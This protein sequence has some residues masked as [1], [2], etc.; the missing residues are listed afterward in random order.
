[1]Q[2]TCCP[3]TCRCASCG[4]CRA[5]C[6][7][8]CC[9]PWRGGGTP[10]QSWRVSRRAAG[11]SA[12][13]APGCL[14]ALP[15]ACRSGCSP[16][17]PPA[18]GPSKPLPSSPCL[19]A[20]WPT[21]R[22]WATCSSTSCCLSVPSDGWRPRC[23]C[24]RTAATCRCWCTA[25]TVGAAAAAAASAAPAIAA[26]GV[27]IA[28]STR[29]WH[30]QVLPV[31]LRVAAFNSLR[32]T[33]CPPPC[34]PTPPHPTP[35][36]ARTAQGWWPCSCCC[37]AGRSTRQARGVSC[38]AAWPL[39]GWLG[40]A[41]QH[42]S[43]HQPWRRPGAEAAHPAPALKFTSLT[44]ACLAG[45]LLQAV[46]RDYALSEVLLRESR[47]KRELLGLAEHLTTDQAGPGAGPPPAC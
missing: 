19:Q 46:V 41:A 30:W 16:R 15:L 42:G 38:L 43:S 9:G 22:S 28:H 33:C 21:P 7:R 36:Q 6:R 10:S 37:S 17:K 31:H 18:P 45:K 44:P 14:P 24:A 40:G 20:L 27:Q 4:S 12:G 35:V 13:A 34:S 39:V 2:S 26:E 23:G 47:E 32:P 25:Y 8:A 3:P 11:E 5:A 29:A 1:M